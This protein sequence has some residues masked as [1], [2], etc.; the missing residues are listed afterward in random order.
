MSDITIKRIVASSYPRNGIAGLGFDVTIF[1]EAEHG[2]MLAVDFG[3]NA[4]K[5]AGNVVCA[6]FQLEELGKGNIAF[7]HGNSWRGDRYAAALR[8]VLE[9]WQE[10]NGTN[11]MGPFALP[12]PRTVQP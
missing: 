11:Q 3:P 9:G 10:K 5:A 7:A 6:V 12:D 8:P 2:L 4:D 1:E